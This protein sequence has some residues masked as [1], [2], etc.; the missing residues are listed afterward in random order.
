MR[1]V[2]FHCSDADHVLIDSRGAALNDFSEICAH[3]DRVVRSMIMTPNA[4][5]WRAWVLRVTD[6]HGDE[7]FAVPFA[8]ALGKLH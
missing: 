4:E 3:A 5:D 6:E 8:S 7:I 1:E 2:Y